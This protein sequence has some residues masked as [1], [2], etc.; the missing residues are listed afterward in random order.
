MF[1]AVKNGLNFH[2][3]SVTI[4]I[5]VRFLEDLVDLILISFKA[6]VL[7]SQ[8]IKRAMKNHNPLIILIKN[9]FIYR[10]GPVTLLLIQQ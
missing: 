5:F 9:V 2:G 8:E 1:R 10:L 3:I 7:S 4:L 6:S